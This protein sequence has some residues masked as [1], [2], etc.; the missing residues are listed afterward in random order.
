MMNRVKKVKST[1]KVD[2]YEK[3]VNSVYPETS[4]PTERANLLIQAIESNLIIRDKRPKIVPLTLYEVQK[5]LLRSLAGRDGLLKYRQGGFSTIITAAT[6]LRTYCASEVT[7]VSVAQ[8]DGT[9]VNFFEIIS[10]Y[11]DNLRTE[12]KLPLEIANRHEIRFAHTGSKYV[13]FSGQKGQRAIGTQRYGSSSLG[14]SYTINN[15]HITEAAFIPHQADLF[16][17]LIEAVPQNGWVMIESTPN[18]ASGWFYDFCMDCLG[19][20]GVYS[21]QFYPWWMDPNYKIDIAQAR[22]HLG[23][24]T[25]RMRDSMIPTWNNLST[26]E[27]TLVDVHKLSLDQIAWRRW[28]IASMKSSEVVSGARASTAEEAFC[29][30][31]PEDPKDCFLTTSRPYFDLS[32]VQFKVLPKTRDPIRRM[33]NVILIYGEPIPGHDYIIGSDVA[34]GL[35]EGHP[36][37][38]FIL[39]ATTGIQAGE[40]HCFL[41]PHIYA[42]ILKIAA[43]YYNDALIVPERNNHGHV[44]IDNL[45]HHLLYPN[46]YFH[47]SRERR[48]KRKT[49]RPGLPT[50]VE[51]RPLILAALKRLVE[52]EQA[53][54]IRSRPLVNEMTIFQYNDQGTPMASV[55]GFDDRVFGAALACYVFD[56][57]R[58]N[59]MEE[60]YT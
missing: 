23:L 9:V 36:S 4:N 45:L 15:L 37:A 17:A 40:I 27:K 48:T 39:D 26:H 41:A 52:D 28:K 3:L 18:G 19:D 6:F 16:K 33:E 31:Y 30:E 29:Q 49:R 8:D 22:G 25:I 10:R 14:R 43:E 11:Y 2:E 38:A 44:V 46:V 5:E 7:T 56:R 21:L 58:S 57:Y 35:S 13:V 24:G 50:N 51:T 1:F 55:G 60:A 32:H 53:I 47:V 12:V 34:E 54:T 59:V 20:R 42:K